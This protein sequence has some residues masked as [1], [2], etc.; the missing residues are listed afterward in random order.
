[1][2]LGAGVTQLLGGVLNAAVTLRF[3]WEML[4][5]GNYCWQELQRPRNSYYLP[6][7]CSLVTHHAIVVVNESTLTIDLFLVHFIERKNNKRL[8]LCLYGFWLATF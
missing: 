4:H 7:V 8:A 3:C 6:C 5:V 1:M 2:V